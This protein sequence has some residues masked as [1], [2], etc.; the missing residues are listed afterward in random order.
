[1]KKRRSLFEGRIPLTA[2]DIYG[3]LPE[4]DIGN[5]GTA[6]QDALAAQRDAAAPNYANTTSL[7]SPAKVIIPTVEP[8]VAEA[9]VL[10]APV[11]TSAPRISS[12]TPKLTVPSILISENQPAPKKKLKKSGAAKRKKSAEVKA[13]R[14]ASN[15][16]LCSPARAAFATSL[17][18]LLHLNQSACDVYQ[19][20]LGLSHDLGTDE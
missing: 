5:G 14:A 20:L 13:L 6:L 3:D 4:D 17:K 19:Y 11:V 18:P 2:Q 7:P 12:P 16:A 1:M 15:L 9:P 10:P 8:P